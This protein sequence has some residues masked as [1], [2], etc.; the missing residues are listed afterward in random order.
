MSASLRSH[1]VALLQRGKPIPMVGRL[2]TGKRADGVEVPLD[3]STGNEIQASDDRPAF[4]LS[5]EDE[6]TDGHIVRQ[7]WDLSRGQ[8]GGPGV[9]TLWGHDA[10][11]LLG[12]WQELQVQTINGKKCLIGRIYFDPEDPDAQ[13]RKGQIKRGILNA[14]SVGW[15]PG[16]TVRRGELD[17]SDPLYKEPVDGL[18]GPEEGM[19]MGTAEEPNTLIECSLVSTP[20]Q[21]NA[22]VT[23]RLYSRA[24][25]GA[26]AV[27]RDQMPMAGDLDALLNQLSEDPRVLRWAENL[28]QR[29]AGKSVSVSTAPKE[30][31]IEDLFPVGR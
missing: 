8:P 24:A 3:P 16:A 26:G 25:R 14:V 28:V 29:V 21:A 20:A 31:S 12:Q 23:E 11:R 4:V 7:F 10:D 22:V 19:A 18:C 17:P 2:Y 27:E 9:P 13:H 15:L 5:T 1:L 30:R 6:A